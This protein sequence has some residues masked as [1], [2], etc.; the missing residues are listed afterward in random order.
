MM[1]AA[2]SYSKSI[3]QLQL[4]APDFS[5]PPFPPS[6]KYTSIFVLLPLS[7][8]STNPYTR[9]PPSHQPPIL[10]SS[11]SQSF[12]PFTHRHGTLSQPTTGAFSGE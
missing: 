11:S 2:F 1:R 10:F 9:F 5:P 6:A 12:P 4:C 3:H 7:R 8:L